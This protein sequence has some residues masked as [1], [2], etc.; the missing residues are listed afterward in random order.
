MIG[1]EPWDAEWAADLASQALNYLARFYPECSGSEVL[2]AHE[3]AAHRA[4]MDADEESYRE[5][6]RAYCRAGRDEALRV[7]RRAA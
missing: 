2:R 6:L 1:K 7:R 5:A 3:D 4:A